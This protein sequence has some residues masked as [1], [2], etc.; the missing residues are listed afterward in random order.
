LADE[1]HVTLGGLLAWLADR[2]RYQRDMRRANEVMERMQREDP[3]A[4]QDYVSELRGFERGTARD[5]P[6][7]TG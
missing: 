5:W 2:E 4:W 3:L 7:G 6:S 1:D